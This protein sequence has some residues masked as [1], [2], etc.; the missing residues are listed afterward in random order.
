MRLSNSTNGF[1]SVKYL[2]ENNI[3]VDRIL[4]FTDCQLYDS[5]GGFSWLS[6]ESDE[7]TIRKN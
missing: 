7:H 3:K 1:L 6:S 5:S 2:N 4:V